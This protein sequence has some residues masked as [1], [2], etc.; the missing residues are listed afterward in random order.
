MSFLALDIP[1]RN[2]DLPPWLERHLVGLKLADVV[3]GFEV[4]Q[5]PM[6]PR[7]EL[8]NALGEHAQTVLAQG[9]AALPEEKLR[10]LLRHPRLLLE[11]QERVFR[12]GGQHWRNVPITPQHQKLVD[13]GFTACERSL[14]RPAAQAES[15]QTLVGGGLPARRTLWRQVLAVAALLLVAVLG[16]RQFQTP[17]VGTAVAWGWSRPEAID[18]RLSP[19][20][21]LD[22]LA[23]AASEWFNQR[24]ERDV[25]LRR[26]LEEFRD[27]CDTL[28]AAPHT[29]L[30]DDD[31]QWLIERCQAWRG[32]IDAHLAAL[33]AGT[34]PLEV[35]QEADAT[36]NALMK[37][38]RERAAAAA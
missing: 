8:D 13:D 23:A 31:R 2:A 15:P 16:W 4:C 27:G 24:P 34:D 18:T 25:P 35:R 22:Q 11:L 14:A 36:V 21:Y 3:A 19:P 20:E 1:D 32:K 17:A 37:A 38:L 29:P 26:R 33:D 12:H 7:P 6:G 30:A 28:L 9:L 10:T 5:P